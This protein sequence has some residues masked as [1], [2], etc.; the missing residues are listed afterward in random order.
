M[1]VCFIVKQSKEKAF[2]KII[3]QSTISEALIRKRAIDFEYIGYS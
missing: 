3:E 1:R 2:K